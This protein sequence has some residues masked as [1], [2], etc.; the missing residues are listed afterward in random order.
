MDSTEATV[1]LLYS[2]GTVATVPNFIYL[3]FSV[4]GL[5]FFFLNIYVGWH[6]YCYTDTINFTIFLQILKYQFL[7]SRNKIIKY[8]TMT[9]HN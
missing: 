8:E 9:N 2:T 5:C 7:T 1:L 4:I 3:F 6:I